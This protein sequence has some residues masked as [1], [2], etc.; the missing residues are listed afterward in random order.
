MKK[1]HI[2]LIDDDLD[3]FG[4][5]LMP[6]EEIPELFKCTYAGRGPEAL[7]LLKQQEPDFIFLDMNMPVWNGL[8]CLKEIRKIEK[9]Q[10][11]PIIL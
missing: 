1:H 4:F 6:L 7:Q 2:L 8:E 3:E 10:H 9:Y 11:I 5:F